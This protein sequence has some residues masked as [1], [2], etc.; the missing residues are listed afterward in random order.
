MRYRI[1]ADRLGDDIEMY[2]EESRSITEH[3]T[4][5]PPSA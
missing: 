4:N 2:K 3:Q 1:A 5:P